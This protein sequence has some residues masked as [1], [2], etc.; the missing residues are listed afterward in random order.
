MLNTVRKVVIPAA[1]LG[2]RLLPAT[3][4]VPK[5][6]LPV[7]GRPVIQF[8][9]EEAARAGL[10]LVVLVISPGSLIPLHFHPNRQ[11]EQL[12]RRRGNQQEAE[13]LNGLS[14]IVE[15]RT[16]VQQ[17]PLGL[18]DAIRQTQS[19]IG[20][21]PFAVILPDAIIDSEMP[22]LGQLTNCY[23]R[24]RGC[25][26]ATQKVPPADVERFG[27][28]DVAP[29]ENHT[30]DS[31]LFRVTSL[32]ERPPRSSASSEYGIFG[33]YILDP[34][35]FTCIDELGP[36]FGGELQLTDALKLYSRSMSVY[37]YE[38]KGDHYDVGNK[39]G[40]LLANIEYALK[41]PQIAAPLREYITTVELLS[42][43]CP[44]I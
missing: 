14:A 29:L 37:A 31:G 34:K 1:G 23:E 41:D 30:S 2:T 33:R 4:V 10:E 7:A 19:I 26:V 6:L 28:I 16:V 39:L 9:I 12:L 17:V 20:A 35:I 25:L 21:E 42:G 43:I 38:F 40:Y 8:A 22:V 11:L 32:T 36:G 27:I 18:A 3:K 24:C 15:I 13:A 5:E 44:S